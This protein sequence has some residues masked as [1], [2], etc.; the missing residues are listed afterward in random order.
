MRTIAKWGFLSVV[1]IIALFLIVGVIGM[2]AGVNP[3]DTGTGS[4][5][6]AP[7]KQDQ[8]ANKPDPQPKESKPAPKPKPQPVKKMPAKTHS[9][10]RRVRAAA[11]A[12]YANVEYTDWDYTY[13]HLASET[14]NTYGRD[15][16]A[17]KNAALYDP[18]ID[19]KVDS[20]V[21]E[22]P[23]KADVVVVLML[24]DGSTNVRNTYFVKENGQWLHQ[25]GAEEYALL[26]GAGSSAS[27]L[28]ALPPAP[29]PWETS[30]ATT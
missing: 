7:Q 20:V 27:P 28:R 14:R 21:M 3:D 22:S 24:G 19:Y 9:P 16:W 29:F 12:Y 10:E 5:N 8:Q 26:A 17:N 15:A 11:E 30:T 2:V 1:G 6:P 13:N 23:T 25:F 4:N 18:S